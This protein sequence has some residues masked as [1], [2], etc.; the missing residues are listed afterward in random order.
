M[1]RLERG[2]AGR[3][4]SREPFA[5]LVAHARYERWSQGGLAVVAAG[6]LTAVGASVWT[7]RVRRAARA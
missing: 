5:G 7:A 2:D 6:L 4:A 3:P 1:Q